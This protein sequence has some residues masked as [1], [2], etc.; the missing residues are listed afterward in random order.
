MAALLVFLEQ[1]VEALPLD[2]RAAAAV[3][4][5]AYPG[6]DVVDAAQHAPRLLGLLA[7]LDVRVEIAERERVLAQ[8]AREPVAAAVV[9]ALRGLRP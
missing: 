4:D 5:F 8:D 3:Q 6:V 9:L 1:F 7:R 2:L